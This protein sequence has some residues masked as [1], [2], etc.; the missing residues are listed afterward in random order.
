MEE[1]LIKAERRSGKGKSLAKKLRKDGKVPAVV[2][3]RDTEPVPVA[4]SSREWDKLSKHVRRNVILTMELEKDG[5]KE[6][7]PV[8]VKE[9]QRSVLADRVLHIDFLQVSMERLIEVEIPIAFTGVA[10]GVTNGGILEPHLR[11]IRVECLP[12]KIPEKI[13]IDVSGLDMAESFHVHQISIPGVK[14]LEPPDVA[15][16]TVIPP[17]A[18]EKAAVVEEAEK[19]VEKKE[20]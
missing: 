15:I 8:M 3:G 14:F 7:R 4:I 6:T 12:T 9:I 18:E 1:V 19:V 17:R 16:V 10:K 2:Y 13:E 20:E 5:Q 11:T